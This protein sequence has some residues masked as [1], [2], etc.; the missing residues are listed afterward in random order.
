MLGL[1]AA[2]PTPAVSPSARALFPPDTFE[3]ATSQL[4]AGWREQVAGPWRQAH[5][6]LLGQ[7][8]R[9]EELRRQAGAAELPLPERIECALLTEAVE[10]SALARPLYSRLFQESPDN[11]LLIYTEGRLL[12]EAGEEAGVR[13][14]D[15]AATM[16]LDHALHACELV[17]RFFIEQERRDEADPWIKRATA[18]VERLERDREERG[19]LPF[20][21]VYQPHG[22]EFSGLSPVL[23][24]LRALP[25]VTEAFL[26]QRSLTVRPEKPLFVL[27]IRLKKKW[28]QSDAQMMTPA[29]GMCTGLAALDVF[30]GETS[31]LALHGQNYPLLAIF[32]AVPG[33]TLDLG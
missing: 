1:E 12:L 18:A 26:V 6:E 15:K 5:E 23:D 8:Q 32:R 28:Y 10:G 2:A 25:E 27:G 7:K 16:D 3:A 24:A 17:V 20:T 9:L 29:E 13:L 21:A 31:I 11:P 4:N 19:L 33:A 22:V 14:L 30:P